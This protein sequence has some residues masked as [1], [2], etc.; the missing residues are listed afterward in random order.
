V[1]A[2]SSSAP[3]LP[4]C[5]TTITDWSEDVRAGPE[6]TVAGALAD[7]DKDGTGTIDFQKFLGMM[8]ARWYGPAL[9]GLFI[10]R[11]CRRVC[12][13]VMNVACGRRVECVR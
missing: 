5:A 10:A 1:R 12:C 6:E 11:C 13:L 8:T 2:C 9:L 4:P 3:P 7:I